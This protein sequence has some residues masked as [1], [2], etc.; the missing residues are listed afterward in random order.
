MV[1]EAVSHIMIP[2]ILDYMYYKSSA[3][4]CPSWL[5]DFL[6]MLQGRTFDHNHLAI[7][8]QITA[9]YQIVCP[10]SVY[11][12]CH[13]R[14]EPWGREVGS[15]VDGAGNRL[16]TECTPA[17]SPELFGN[18]A[19]WLLIAHLRRSQE[20]KIL[21]AHCGPR[22]AWHWAWKAIL[23]RWLEITLW[24]WML[25]VRA[26]WAVARTPFCYYCLLSCLEIHQR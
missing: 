1:S 3:A 5:Q 7:A 8:I 26:S 24:F 9:V 16:R 15:W 11:S 4:P 22:T 13:T 14:L 6:Q 20:S 12:G 21:A 2:S 17:L 10:Y 18:P 23:T 25:I 19:T